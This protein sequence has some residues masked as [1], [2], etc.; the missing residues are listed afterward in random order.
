MNQPLYFEHLHIGDRWVSQSRTIT[1]ADVVLFA[2]LTG[3]YDPLH[4]DHHFALQTPYRKPIAHGLLGLSWLAGLSSHYPRACTMA[5]V[6]ILNWE[7]RKP[8]FIGDTVHVVTQVVAKQP[9]GRRNGMVTWH[10]ELINQD[11]AVTQA[12]KFET[13]VAL[14]HTAQRHANIPP[15]HTHHSTTADVEID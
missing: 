9:H 13:L 4:V 3:D 14:E 5:F 2:G 12:G 15:P 7:F 10:R 6:S 11:G 1:E 8:L